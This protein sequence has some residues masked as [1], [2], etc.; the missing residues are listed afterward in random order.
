MA[1]LLF[2]SVDPR[3]GTGYGM[4]TRTQVPRLASLGH[5]VAI[6]A[7]AGA[8]A[9]VSE[10]EGFTVYPGGGHRYGADVLPLHARHFRPDLVITLC[11][12]WALGSGPFPAMP[13]VRAACWMP[14]DCEPL[15]RRDRGVL[16]QARVTPLAMSRHGE[17]MLFGA[18]FRSLY[19]PHGVDASVFRPPEDRAELR[20]E[21]GIHDRFVIGICAT[22][23]DEWRKGWFEQLT[24][25]ARL[26]RRH[27]D[28]LLIAH[29]QPEAE[30]GIDLMVL[31]AQLGIE[32]AVRWTDP[33]LS[34][35]G[36]VTPGQMAATAGAEDLRSGCAWGE[37]FGLPLAEAQ[38]CGTPAVAT[39]ASAMRDVCGGWLVPGEEAYIPKQ[40]AKWVKPSIDAIARVY[41]K[42]YQQGA[43]Y[44]AKKTAA[45]E[46][47]MQYDADRVL[48]E[49]W[50]PALEAL[51]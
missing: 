18:G 26:H 50:K 34:E 21:M 38:L 28:A 9:A 7:F 8:P 29:T 16:G 19:V 46:Y 2:H 6:S 25:F 11:D 44:Q 33:Y 43:A 3:A 23:N 4:Q 27:D 5:E 13:G 49:H 30:A 1:R 24:A 47:A 48:T 40:Q 36:F 12:L 10:W 42:A 14:V 15:G 37:G 32:K 41:E 35:A 45:R 20:R 31:A 39:D 51:L 22:N 17:K